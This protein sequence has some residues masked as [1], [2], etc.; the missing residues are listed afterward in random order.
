MLSFKMTTEKENMD[1]DY[2]RFSAFWEKA[3]KWRDEDGDE[4]IDWDK[5]VIGQFC[6]NNG[7]EAGKAEAIK[8]IKVVYKKL[9]CRCLKVKGVCRSCD[10]WELVESKLGELAK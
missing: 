5:S 1:R 3:R 8:Q 4:F 7:F 9:F 10:D 2:K 6:F